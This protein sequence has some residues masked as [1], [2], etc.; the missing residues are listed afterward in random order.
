M[1]TS[2]LN[3][4][5]D[6]RLRRTYGITLAEHKKI[7]A[8]Q[9]NAC[10]ICKRSVKEFRNRLSVDHCHTGGIV[11]GLLC[12]GCNKALAVFKDDPMRLQAAA[13]YLIHPPAV[14]ALNK[15]VVTA[16]G[17]VGSKKRAKLLKAMQQQMEAA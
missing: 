12:W 1:T 14:L 9:K 17:R 10:A 3:K 6:L 16:P 13:D 5:A 8:Y 7:Q 2:K 4:A 11:R 15:V